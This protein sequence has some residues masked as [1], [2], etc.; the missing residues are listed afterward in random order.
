MS[1]P[2]R[3]RNGLLALGVA[4][5]LAVPARG[6]PAPAPTERGSVEFTPGDDPVRVPER[7]RLGAFR[8]PFEL[9]LK[10]DLPY[11]GVEVYRLTFPSPVKSPHESNNTVHAEYYRP[12]GA[13]PFPG[14]I[15]LDILAGDQSLSRGMG[16]FFAQNGVAGLFVQMA[17]HGPRRPPE[18]R[19][20]LLS[21]DIPHTLA[22]IR[23]TVLDCRCAAAWLAARPEIDPERLGIVGTSLGSF[24]S[25]L[26]A[27]MEP[28]LRRVALLLGG[29]GLVDAFYDHPRAGW[30]RR[31][32]ELL[33]GSKERL[34]ELIAP[35]DPLTYADRLARRRLLMIAA[36]RDE[37][38]PPSA[39]EALWKAAGRQKIVWFDTTHYGAVLYLLPAM[40]Y[41]L[42]HFR[43]P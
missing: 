18:G 35:V 36:R 15:I 19:V 39:A 5:C 3:V 4:G 33:G 29:G 13:G 30:F 27:A 10:Y 38:V 16:L 40:G 22:A 11:S 20:R 43:S 42:E 14:V 2:R 9:S 34:A 31:F 26:T 6:E 37:I 23:Q 25:A 7:Y 41:V 32:N 8:F 28:R 17:Y 1:L 24:M 21:P 12:K